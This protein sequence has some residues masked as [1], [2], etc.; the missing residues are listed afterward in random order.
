[1]SDAA[2]LFV[3]L[4]ISIAED[5]QGANGE[6]AEV[7]Q[8]E[9]PPQPPGGTFEDSSAVSRDDGPN[10]GMQFRCILEN[11]IEEVDATA[12]RVPARVRVLSPMNDMKLPRSTRL[13]VP[14]LHDGHI[15]SYCNGT[16]RTAEST[17][18]Q[19]MRAGDPLCFEKLRP[20]TTKSFA[21]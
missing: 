20:F 4:V 15:C 1:M 18:V 8:P 3:P 11:T 13:H 10:Y 19:R 7:P 21:S 2:P 6:V 9:K 17:W 12:G 5:D 16:Q 14:R